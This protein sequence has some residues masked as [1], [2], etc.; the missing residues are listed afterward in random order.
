VCVWCV[1]VRVCAYVRVCKCANVCMRLCMFLHV[2]A[3]VSVCMWVCEKKIVHTH[4]LTHTHTHTHTHTYRALKPII[5]SKVHVYVKKYIYAYIRTYIHTDVRNTY[6]HTYVRICTHT[7]IPG[8]LANHLRQGSLPYGVAEWN[9]RSLSQK[10]PIK[11]TIF[12]IAPCIQGQKGDM[13]WLRLVGSL[14]S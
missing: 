10:S 2:F 13:G 11:E 3:C 5:F 7:H 1:R 4:T 14:K 9:Y 12:S 8:T 6:V